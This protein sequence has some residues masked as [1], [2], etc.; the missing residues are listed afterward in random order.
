[1]AKTEVVPPP[2]AEITHAI[3]HELLPAKG[4]SPKSFVVVFFR[5]VLFFAIPSLRQ[6]HRC[7]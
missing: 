3:T 1:M 5:V 2:V 4:V 6:Q 7:H